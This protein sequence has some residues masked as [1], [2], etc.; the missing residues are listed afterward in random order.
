MLI[1][2]AL[3]TH[4]HITN[5]AEDDKSRQLTVLAGDYFSGLYYKLLADSEDILM[6]KALSDGVKTIN[7]SKV[8]IYQKESIEIDKLMNCIMIIESSLLAKFSEYFKVDLWNEFHGNFLFFK[9]F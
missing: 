3:D 9:R 6:I 5:T 1:Q 2:I 7:E 4:E 8:L